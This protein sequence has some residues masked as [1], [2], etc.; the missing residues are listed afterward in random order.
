MGLPTIGT[1]MATAPTS[2]ANPIAPNRWRA[3]ASWAR[4]RGSRSRGRPTRASSCP[5]GRAVGPA[6][7]VEAGVARYSA[8]C[9]SAVVNQPPRLGLPERHR[10]RSGLTDVMAS[11]PTSRGSGSSTI[12]GYAA[13]VN[14]RERRHR[15]RA[16]QPGE[17]RPAAAD[18]RA[19]PT[20]CGAAG[21]TDARAAPPAGRINQAR[22]GAAGAHPPG[23]RSGRTRRGPSAMRSSWPSATLAGGDVEDRQRR[24]GPEPPAAGMRD[25]AD[26]RDER[27]AVGAEQRRTRHGHAAV[28]HDDMAECLV[29]ED[30]R[31]PVRS[32]DASCR[33]SSDQP[34]APPMTARKLSRR[35]ESS[36]IATTPGWPDLRPTPPTSPP[37]RGGR[38]PCRIRRPPRRTRAPRAAARDRQAPGRPEPPRRG[39]RAALAQPRSSSSILVSMAA[40]SP[41]SSARRTWLRPSSGRPLASHVA[42]PSTATVAPGRRAMAESAA[43]SAASESVKPRA[44]RQ[45]R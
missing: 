41:W 30:A 29:R 37:S 23:T 4:R 8:I 26:V 42:S 35:A 6:D 20:R 12:R 24:S 7:L 9:G 2:S 15:C 27:V 21:R 1:T 19:A 45:R 33:P 28:A 38:G 10:A 39:H 16:G 11:S 13:G 5:P 22:S 36:T 44:P 32:A 34:Y 40:S 25:R 3:R 43:T 14:G 31:Q 17:V 18:A